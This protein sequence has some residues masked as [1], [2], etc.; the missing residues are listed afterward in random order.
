MTV[1]RVR[2]DRDGSAHAAAV[3]GGPALGHPASMGPGSPSRVTAGLL[4]L[5]DVRPVTIL[6]A[7]LSVVALVGMADSLTG[8]DLS[9]SI[10]YILPPLIATTKGRTSGL[11]VAATASGTWFLADLSTRVTPYSS[12]AVPI[13]NV[14]MRFIVIV[15]VVALVDALLGSALHER[16][17]AR[18]D[19]LTGLQNSRAF[20]DSAEAELRGSARTG[21][22]LTLAYI[23]IDQFKTVNDLLGHAAGDAVLV[24][25]GHVLAMETREVDTVARIGGDEFMVLLPETDADQAQVALGRVHRGLVEAAIASGWDVGYSVGAVTFTSPP[26]SIEAMVARADQLMYEVKQSDK[27]T[28]RFSAV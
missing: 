4:R 27:G 2:Q 24:G 7:C 26:D 11:I 15:L 12:I 19:H 16:Q 6:V 8:H 28:I 1:P 21:R 10:F 9:L 22:P 25:T 23:D 5:A 17:L 3:F 20:Y 13:W 14:M 18:R